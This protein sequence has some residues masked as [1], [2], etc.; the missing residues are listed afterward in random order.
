M[1]RRIASHRTAL[2][3]F[4]LNSN[5]TK[6]EFCDLENMKNVLRWTGQLRRVQPGANK[7]QVTNRESKLSSVKG[8]SKIVMSDLQTLGLLAWPRDASDASAPERFKPECPAQAKC[9]TCRVTV[10]AETNRVSQI[11]LELK[12][13]SSTRLIF[14]SLYWAIFVHSNELFSNFLSWNRKSATFKSIF[15]C[16]NESNKISSVSQ[17]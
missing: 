5:G 17:R 13:D 6:L 3:W 4:E 15:F 10:G 16:M 14:S 11:L 1:S 9:K 2:D 12:Y 8:K 7:L